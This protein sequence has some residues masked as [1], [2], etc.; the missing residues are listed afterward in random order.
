MIH[1]IISDTHKESLRTLVKLVRAKTIPEEFAV[2]HTS[3]GAKT[4]HSKA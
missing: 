1:D 4:E 3:K 2:I